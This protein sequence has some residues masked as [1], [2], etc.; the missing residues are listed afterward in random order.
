MLKQARNI[1]LYQK[2]YNNKQ[3]ITLL[4]C[5]RSN[6]DFAKLRDFSTNS[7][8]NATNPSAPAS[9]ATA[10]GTQQQQQKAT[11]GPI[12]TAAPPRPLKNISIHSLAEM[13]KKKIPISMF[14][15]YDFPSAVHVDKAGID[16]LLV[17]DSVGMVELGMDTTLPVTIDDM[18]HHCK[19]VSRGCHRPLLIGD[20]PFGTYEADPKQAVM[21]AARIL[22][23]GRMVSYILLISLIHICQAIDA[24]IM[25]MIE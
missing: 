13:K 17:G 16:V 8:S 25:V 20:L 9:S 2:I 23:E 7:N 14:T 6:V 22:K 10:S 5:P 4:T 15:A 1:A 3:H 21:N 18:V 11:S 19:A 12:I 24:T